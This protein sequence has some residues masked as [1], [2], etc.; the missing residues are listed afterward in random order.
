MKDPGT[1][2]LVYKSLNITV[3]NYLNGNGAHLNV[4]SK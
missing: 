4:P 1:I 2:K 3:I